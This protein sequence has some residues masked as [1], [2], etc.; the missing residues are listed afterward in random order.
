MNIYFGHSTDIDY[1]KKIYT[2]IRNSWISHSHNVVLPHEK[3]TKPYNSKEFLGE[4]DLFVAEVS[5][6]STGL[7][8]ELGWA[9][10]M[11]VPIL[12]V[13]KKG[14]RTSSSLNVVSE[15]IIEY[16]DESDLITKL[17]EFLSK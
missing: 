2:P 15:D 1:K 8:I 17:S 11:N 7:G 3:T 9:D 12:F 6:K 4:C 13:H 10:S 14:T 16:K 5:A